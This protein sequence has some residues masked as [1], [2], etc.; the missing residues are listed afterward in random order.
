MEPTK[1]A[2]PNPNIKPYRELNDNG[3]PIL[4]IHG[5]YKDLDCS[6]IIED[7]V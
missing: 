6:Y 7:N 4:Y 1:S 2:L 5:Y 3:I